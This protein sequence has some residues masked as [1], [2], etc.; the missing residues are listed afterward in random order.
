MV[1]I[2]KFEDVSDSWSATVYDISAFS[3]SEVFD[4]V[5][6]TNDFCGK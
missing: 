3:E 6:T 4:T 5:E 1:V 2:T